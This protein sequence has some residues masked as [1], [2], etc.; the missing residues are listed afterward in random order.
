MATKMHDVVVTCSLKSQTVWQKCVHRTQ[1]PLPCFTLYLIEIAYLYSQYQNLMNSQ[2]DLDTRKPVFRVCE[3]KRRRPACSS[4]Q[5]DQHL[6]Y[7]R[8]RE[9]HI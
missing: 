8:I 7:L 1:I 9:N 5:S 6:Y 2:M 4:G 3:Q